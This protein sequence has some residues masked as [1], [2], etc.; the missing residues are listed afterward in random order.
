MIRKKQPLFVHP[1][2]PLAQFTDVLHEVWQL[3]VLEDKR[4][5]HIEAHYE[6]NG[7]I[8]TLRCYSRVIRAGVDSG[9][10]M[11][12]FPWYGG[13]S[14]QLYKLFNVAKGWRCVGID[15]FSTRE[16]F[17]AILSSALGSQYAYALA[18]RMTAEQIH[19][20]HNAHKRVGAIGFSF[21]A[22]VLSAYV[23]QGLEL[24]DAVVSIEGG[25]I[26]ETALQTKYR[27]HDVDPQTLAV[28]NREPGILP[29]QKPITGKAASLSA[30][31]INDTDTIVLGQSALWGNAAH[32]MHISGRHFR[33]PF[34]KQA[35]I[36]LFIRNH[37]EELL[38]G[39]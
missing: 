5:Q 30:A 11:L 1:N 23:S 8:C 37:C 36:R 34:L 9:P 20:V 31:V 13:K 6:F 32:K 26:L 17:R 22:N 28:L 21:G 39:Y 12:Y 15:V 38:V 7:Q 3:P 29:I 24:P 33:T 25:D 19:A 14:T 35:K 4:G 2:R 27:K 10:V 16:D 18:M